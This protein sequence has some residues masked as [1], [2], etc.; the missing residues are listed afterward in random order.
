[1][2]N[3]LLAPADA[4][5]SA[6]CTQS[7]DSNTV[8]TATTHPASNSL[9]APDGSITLVPAAKSNSQTG[10]R[11]SSTSRN[12]RQHVG[13]SGSSEAGFGI[14]GANV[15]GLQ[16]MMMMNSHTRQMLR[17]PFREV[18]GDYKEAKANLTTAIA[19]EDQDDIKFY[20]AACEA[21]EDELKSFH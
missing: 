6:T 8:E 14:M 10:S 11:V 4:L 19:A 21:L 13:N 17:R 12:V 3:T 16:E 20:R 15:G 1:M 18:N 7:R 9:I 5:D 2:R